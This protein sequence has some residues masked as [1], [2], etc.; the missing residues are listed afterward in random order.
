MTGSP[1][2]LNSSDVDYDTTASASCFRPVM[3]K[4]IFGVVQD[5]VEIEPLKARTE[6]YGG[7]AVA[8]VEMMQ[9]FRPSGP[10]IASGCCWCDSRAPKLRT[11]QRAGVVNRHQGATAKTT[12]R[13]SLGLHLDIGPC[14]CCSYF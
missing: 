6:E 1:F 7:D 9:V 12:R 2:S 13:T 4:K 8:Y 10:N 14:S 11:R 5:L 3:F